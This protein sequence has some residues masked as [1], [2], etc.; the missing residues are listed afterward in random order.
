MKK[1]NGFIVIS[2]LLFL[3]GCGTSVKVTDAWQADDI[4]E[5]R[6]EQYLV[7]A[8]VDDQVGRQRFEQEIST[9]LRAGGIKAVESYKQYPSLNVLIQLT[10]EEIDKWV[11][12]IQNE[13][14]NGIVLTVIKDA[15]KE[16]RTSTSGVGV[17]VGYYPGYYDGYGY[18]GDYFGSMYSP[19]G[20]SGAYV[21]VSQ[22]TYTS[23]TYHLESVV[24]DLE[25]ERN[26]QLIAA[27]T[28][29][30]TDPKSAAEVAPKYAD[31]VFAQF[32]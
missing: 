17:G 10:D 16:T 29:D 15:S 28:V 18:F 4:D 14:F 7:I 1:I 27:V 26:K 19:Y 25:R 20:Y 22:R 30:I 13:G 12:G 11:A 9:R 32:E 6:E 3:L 24:Y 2:F 5:A 8:R 21:P 31:K 23:E